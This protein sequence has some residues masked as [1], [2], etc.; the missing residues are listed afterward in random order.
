MLGCHPAG[1]TQL[2]TPHDGGEW[3]ARKPNYGFEKKQREIKKQKKKEKKAEKKRLK[4][5]VDNGEAPIDGSTENEDD[6]Q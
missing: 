1:F 3:V 4:R 6:Q 2:R 5:E